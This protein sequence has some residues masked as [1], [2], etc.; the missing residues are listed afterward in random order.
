[1]AKRKAKK[2]LKGRERRLEK[3]PRWVEKHRG[4]PA[5]M[6]KRYRKFFGVD[7]EC[8]IAELTALGVEFDALY[9]SRLQ[10]SF[11]RD[12]PPEKKHTPITQWEFDRYHGRDPESDGTFAYI[13]GYTA[14]GLPFGVTW[15]EMEQH[16]GENA[17]AE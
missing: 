7:W 17:P 16:D 9:L 11:L 5:N 4:K 10:E 14:G 3:A 15:E 1:M 2:K 12:F 8:A 13:A 6:L